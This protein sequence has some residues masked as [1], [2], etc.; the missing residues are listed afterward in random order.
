M[1][2]IRLKDIM[3]ENGIKNQLTIKRDFIARY[4]IKLENEILRISE[5]VGLAN[6]SVYISKGE[7]WFG[8]NGILYIDVKVIFLNDDERRLSLSLQWNY[9]SFV[10]PVA[11]IDGY[12]WW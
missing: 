10:T 1:R 7:P 3:I 6:V 9:T 2:Y 5:D 12:E 11:V 8:K 4:G